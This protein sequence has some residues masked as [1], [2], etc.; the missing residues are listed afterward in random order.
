MRVGGPGVAP[1]DGVVADGAAG[2]VVERAEDRIPGVLAHVHERDQPGDLVR[3]DHLG[4]DP[5]QLV[6]L[7]PPPHGPQGRVVVGQR[8]V[9]P[10]GEHDVEV[11]LRRQLLVE[12]HRAVVERDAFGCQVVRPHDG[13]VAARSTAP[14]V[15]LVDHRHV[16]D[17]PPRG[18]VVRGGEPVHARADDHRRRTRP[19]DPAARHARGHGR[20]RR[21][22]RTSAAAEYFAGG[23]QRGRPPSR[24]YRRAIVS[25]S[26][27]P[28]ARPWR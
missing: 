16:G 4:V 12:L 14:D 9:P 18:Q 19:A 28:G 10:L 2:R 20:P 25:T 1:V 27:R 7:G 11:Q 5:L 6:D 22:W 13:G 21:P 15:A 26:R 8:Q 17:A 3:A 24:R 23:R